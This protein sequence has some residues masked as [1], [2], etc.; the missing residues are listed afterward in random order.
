MI[1]VYCRN[2]LGNVLFLYAVGRQ[3]ALKNNTGLRMHLAGRNGQDKSILNQLSYFNLQAEVLTADS[4]GFIVPPKL[5]ESFSGDNAYVETT[6]GFN[7]QVLTL[8]ND[9]SLDG[10]FQ[11]EKYF[12]DIEQTI[13]QDFQIKDNLLN[14]EIVAYLEKIKSTNSV[15]VHIRRGDYLNLE[16]HNVCNAAY[17]ANAIEYMDTHLDDPHYFLFSDDINWCV[18]NFDLANCTFVDIAAA[19]SNP[20][21]DFKLMSRCKHNIIANSTFSWWPAWL[22][23]HPGKI[24]LGPKH[25][26]NNE[27]KLN[28]VV[29]QDTIP[30]HWVRIAF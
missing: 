6:W 25:W 10:N 15:A 2:R 1:E 4:D 12:I 7:P 19:K 24:V 20:V 26:F 21:I 5:S 18:K 16:S 8:K 23:T 13:R 28:W 29:C 3:L 22:N 27:G 9:T 30:D 14:G 17:Y 11:C